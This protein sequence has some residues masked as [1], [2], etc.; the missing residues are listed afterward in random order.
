MRR[1]ALI[2]VVCVAGLGFADWCGAQEPPRGRE[3]GVGK[4]HKAMIRAALDDPEFGEKTGIEEEQVEKIRDGL[5]EIRRE[6]IRLHAK[7]DLAALEQAQLM[8]EQD[9]DEEAVLKAVEETGAVRTELAK[10]RVRRVLLLRST[11]TSDQIA[12]AKEFLRERRKDRE[13]DEGPGDRHPR[14]DKEWH[15]NRGRP[16]RR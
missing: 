7:M 14:G 1:V 10:L 2:A 5:F 11:L 8:T 4:W 16:P 9:A 15:K 12:K 6:E 3:D 13:G